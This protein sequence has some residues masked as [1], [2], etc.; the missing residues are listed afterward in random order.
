M[1][2]VDS[3]VLAA[4]LRGPR[5]VA[6]GEA[7]APADSAVADSAVADSGVAAVFVASI[8]LRLMMKIEEMS[9][10]EECVCLV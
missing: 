3:A 1:D 4:G 6:A 5:V 10:L 7:C 2:L 8:R 9:G